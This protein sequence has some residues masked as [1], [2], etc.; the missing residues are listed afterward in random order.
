M[1]D[2]YIIEVLVKP[3]PY[4]STP[5]EDELDEL[6]QILTETVESF[7]DGLAENSDEDG[8][9]EREDD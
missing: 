5:T 8:E 6:G 9:D 3:K 7:L 4:H 1:C 2:E